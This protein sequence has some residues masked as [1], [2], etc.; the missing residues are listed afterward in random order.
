MRKK[1][2]TLI[3]LLVVIAIIAILAGMLL[4][5]LG[6]VREH[7][8]SISCLNNLKQVGAVFQMYSSDNNDCIITSTPL[9]SGNACRWM[10]MVNRYVP[11]IDTS[12]DG[13]YGVL[14]QNCL[15]CCPADRYFNRSYGL[16]LEGVANLSFAKT[17]GNDNP[18]YGIPYWI[19]TMP[20][21][22]VTAVKHPSRK[23]HLTDTYHKEDP[24]MNLEDTSYSFSNVASLGLRHVSKSVNMLWVDGHV[25]NVNYNF[26]Y[27][28]MLSGG[29]VVPEYWRPQW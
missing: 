14:I 1:D 19:T 13:N 21:M 23:V 2:F 7:G 16:Y 27:S 3:E 6:K 18:S 5:A 29:S 15:L 11:V 24:G 26:L 28:E 8:N 4:P 20:G 17:N 9:G 12:I 25:S 10:Q 22:K